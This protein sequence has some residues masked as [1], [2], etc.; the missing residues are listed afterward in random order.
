[1]SFIDTGIGGKM[2]FRSR[3]SIYCKVSEFDSHRVI[4]MPSIFSWIAL[5]TMLTIFPGVAY[6]QA[7]EPEKDA[8]QKRL[9]SFDEERAEALKKGYKEVDLKAADD[10]RSLAEKAAQSSNIDQ[11]RLTLR[12]ARYAIPYL[13][14]DLPAH[15]SK[16]LGSARLQQTGVIASIALHPKEPLCAS[17]AEDGTIVIWNIDNGRAIRTFRE[18]P[19]PCRAVAWSPDGRWIAAGHGKAIYLRDATSGETKAVLKEHKADVCSLCFAADGKMLASTADS[20]DLSIVLWEVESGKKIGVVA[21]ERV[22]IF[23]MAFR[24]YTKSLGIVDGNG[25]FKLYPTAAVKDA[26]VKE[27]YTRNLHH[28]SGAFALAFRPDGGL[29]FT[30]GGDRAIRQTELPD[31]QAKMDKAS[32]ALDTTASHALQVTA[33]AMSSDGRFLASGGKDSII[34]LWDMKTGTAIRTF[35]GHE[36]EISS[37]AFTADSRTLVSGSHDQRI[38]VWDISPTDSH[39]TLTDHTGFI[40]TCAYSPDGKYFATGGADKQVCLYESAT[41]KLLAKIPAHD[42][43]VTALTFSPDS[44]RLYTT[45]GDRL[46]RSWEIPSG[47]PI[48]EYRGHTGPIMALA[49]DKSGKYLLTG[50]ADKT[51]ILWQ[52]E[53]DKPIAHFANLN[54]AVSAVEF[55]PYRDWLAIGTADGT[56]RVFKRSTPTKEEFRVAAHSSGVAS[57]Q[58]QPDAPAQQPTIATSGG[59]HLIRFWSS[60]AN[61]KF[62]PYSEIAAHEKAVS[63]IAYNERGSY[64]ASAG[65]DQFVKIWNSKTRTEKTALRGHTDW[66]TNVAFAPNGSALLSV[67]V[68]KTARIWTLANADSRS[69]VGHHRQVTAI[70]TSA[71]GLVATGSE[72]RT[73]KIWDA[74][75]GREIATLPMNLRQITSLL[76]LPDGKKLY[77]AGN[78]GNARSSEIQ[79]WDVESKA[80][81]KQI[82]G[83]DT[84]PMMI[85]DADKPRILAWNFKLTGTK[86]VSSL[87]AYDLD[88]K[89]LGKLTEK[90]IDTQCLCVSTDNQRLAMGSKE[91]LVRVWS[92]EKQERLLKADLK[93]SEKGV[94]DVCFA[95]D[96][97]KL[98][99]VDERG[100]VKLWNIADSKELKSFDS[101]KGTMVQMLLSPSGKQ[102]MTYDA[103]GEVICWDTE[104]FEKL[105]TWKLP[106][107]VN[108]ISYATDGKSLLT[109]NADSTVY[110]LELP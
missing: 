66:V 75:S 29:V 46:M 53:S 83:L 92:I 77:V 72:D 86:P 30:G 103:T 94:T 61:G 22:R 37:L 101:H 8:F 47:K 15:I 26:P 80:V 17:A 43:A 106:T 57:L 108:A 63:S 89:P 25:N 88:L 49:V 102:L 2:M 100:I 58:F 96:A 81:A 20:P 33:L 64:L 51:A 62:S 9:K 99:T 76:L 110:V 4:T 109:G 42:S 34:K 74:K 32:S 40:W 56:L 104:K 65:G 41:N 39:I 21:K 31:Q 1:M 10:F 48:K 45:G 78:G 18:G 55:S 84:I 59:D 97:S 12:N 70:S 93:A 7:T 85:Y 11:A 14:A 98:F 71:S 38:R 54:S 27:S 28:V 73:V 68:D 50:A 69:N 60:D 95:K 91:G 16:V 52:S 105:R 23:Q 107:K 82:G 90:D 13:P 19:E 67:G 6:S 36:D 44:N 3:L 87:N 35:F 79:I 5:S 24:P